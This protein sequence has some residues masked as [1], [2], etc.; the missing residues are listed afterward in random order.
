M[1]S[2]T[3]A[4]QPELA[5]ERWEKQPE[6][7]NINR[8][9]I[10]SFCCIS[11][12]IKAQRP[13]S[14]I[15]V[16]ILGNHDHQ[17]VCQGQNWAPAALGIMN[18]HGDW[19][20]S[21]LP[22]YLPKTERGA[23]HSTGSA[24]HIS[25]CFL[26]QIKAADDFCQPSDA[27]WQMSHRL[28]SPWFIGWEWPPPQGGAHQTPAKASDRMPTPPTTSSPRL[29]GLYLLL[30]VIVWPSAGFR[31]FLTT[32]LSKHGVS[33]KCHHP[34]YTLHIKLSRI[35]LILHFYVFICFFNLIF[36]VLYNFSCY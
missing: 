1:E 8:F 15:S 14:A 19:I 21:T 9:H 30:L 28:L 29:A 31:P 18:E 34:P 32:T 16:I 36:G 11:K 3:V 6:K 10:C 7:S 27:V 23:A 13:W 4:S 33:A 22:T 12:Q 2:V 17:R 20:C 26:S 24:L 25:A 5:W 35:P